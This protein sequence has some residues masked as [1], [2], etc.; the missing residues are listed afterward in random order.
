L[1]NTVAHAHRIG[2][3]GTTEL[4]TGE[5]EAISVGCTVVFIDATVKMNDT[6]QFFRTLRIRQTRWLPTSESVIIG[7]KETIEIGRD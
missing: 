3:I 5:D 1:P 2:K 4:R 6:F 7:L